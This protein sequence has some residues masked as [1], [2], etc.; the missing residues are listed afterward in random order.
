VLRKRDEQLREEQCVFFSL[1]MFLDEKKRISVFEDAISALLKGRE[2]EAVYPTKL[3]TLKKLPRIPYSYWV[4]E[5]IAALFEKYPPLDKDNTKKKNAEKIADAKQ[6]LASADDKRFL[7]YFWEVPVHNIASTRKEVK[8]GKKWVPF[9]KG[10][11]AYYSDISLVVDWEDEG[12]K[13]REI[14]TSNIHWLTKTIENF[15]FKGGL[16]WSRILSSVLF[17]ARVLPEGVIF[18]SAAISLFPKKQSTLY[19]LLAF[20]NSSLS[21]FLFIILDPTLHMRQAGYVSQVPI[22]PEILKNERLK[23]LA[24]ETHNLKREWDTGNE[25]STRFSKPWILQT[26]HGFDPSEKPITQH[27]LAKQFEWSNLNVIRE[28]VKEIYVARNESIRII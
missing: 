27:P 25:V 14:E 21:A 24:M 16:C 17:D 15:F 22:S 3:E 26:L 12:D 7:R 23:H 2:H 28:L 10:G 19:Q 5:S 20:I 13:I 18:G 8:E 6:G 4:P 11:D 1:T 9:V